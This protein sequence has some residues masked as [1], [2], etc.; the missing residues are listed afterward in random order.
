MG[1]ATFEIGVLRSDGRMILREQWQATE[2]ID[3]LAWLRHEN[4]AGAQI[5]VR[6][7]G[8]HSLTLIDDLTAETVQR[9]AGEGF[10]PA[11]VVETS[12]RNYQAWLKHAEVLDE[13]TSTAAARL[14]AARFGGDPS[15]AD[16]R[17]FG[18]LAGFTNQKLQR[19]LPSGLAPFV[20]LRDCSGEIFSRAQETAREVRRTLAAASRAPSLTPGQDH[21]GTRGLRPIAEFHRDPVYGGDLHRAD[22]A[23]ATQAAGAGLSLEQIRDTIVSARDLRHKGD[24][25]R[26]L[27]YATRTAQ[28]AR[29]PD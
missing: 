20:R 22:L 8:V 2:I 25:K 11:L 26:Q 29:A 9:M 17:H 5:Y 6:P 28:K 27:D 23:W 10:E 3:A 4:A 24:A 13:R 1:C 18:R 14:I 16:W 19:R 15:S 12:R 21:D 7:A